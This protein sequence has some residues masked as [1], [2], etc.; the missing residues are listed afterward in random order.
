MSRPAVV[1][2]RVKRAPQGNHAAESRTVEAQ[3]QGLCDYID[4]VEDDGEKLE[5]RQGEDGEQRDAISFNL[6]FISEDR[7]T[8]IKEF[9][10]DAMANT[11]E[12]ANKIE[13]IVISLEPGKTL[14]A[15]GWKQAVATTLENLGMSDHLCK[16][17]VHNN[18]KNQHAHLLI[19]KVKPEPDA[20][21]KYLIAIDGGSVVTHDDRGRERNNVAFCLQRAASQIAGSHGWEIGKFARFDGNGRS[22]FPQEKK[23][24]AQ[25]Y[26]RQAF[27]GW[28]A[29]RQA[30]PTS[31]TRP[32]SAGK[33]STGKAYTPQTRTPRLI[34]AVVDYDSLLAALERGDFEAV[35]QF[36]KR[37]SEQNRASWAEFDRQMAAMFAA[38]KIEFRASQAAAKAAAREARAEKWAA[39]NAEPPTFRERHYDLE[40]FANPDGLIEKST[41]KVYEREALQRQ[42]SAI[43]PAATS[44]KELRAVLS[45]LQVAIAKKGQGAVLVFQSKTG[46]E[47][48]KLSD[49]GR[50]YSY[51]NLRKLYTD[52]P[53]PTPA[54]KE[55]TPAPAPIVADD[56]REELPAAPPVPGSG[57]VNG[58][59]PIPTYAPIPADVA[60]HTGGPSAGTPGPQAKLV[61][62][63]KKEPVQ[64]DKPSESSKPKDDWL[65][66]A[67]EARAKKELDKRVRYLQIMH[68]QAEVER[69]EKITQAD[70]LAAQQREADRLEWERREYERHIQERE[71][72]MRY[73]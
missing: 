53:F 49:L 29:N 7:D 24:R 37:F 6:N 62:A 59:L 54:K 40:K 44:W 1:I 69:A 48:L 19:C 13:H 64:E 42:L 39:R 14:D 43:L 21:G 32:E 61:P 70:A 23:D 46:R 4:N 57:P 51:G 58:V 12:K 8:Q 31:S 22:F 63:P 25:Q 18:E 30:R 20:N 66:K 9:I 5:A 45:P 41:R 11:N 10:A 38:E 15:E 3:I 27:V 72:R 73:L 28:L 60:G 16:V 71:E 17:T 47:E 55:P 36:W 35:A 2:K 34:G 50:A 56:V 68:E 33:T 65:E 52:E 67:K 26:D